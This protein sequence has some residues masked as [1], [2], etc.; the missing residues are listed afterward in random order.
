MFWRKCVLFILHLVDGHAAGGAVGWGT[1]LQAERSRVRFP[2]VSS[3]FFIDIILQATLWSWGWLSL[4]RNE[5]QEYFLGGK[6]GRCVKSDNLITFMCRLSW[7]LRSSSSWN[8]QGLITPWPG[9]SVGIA[10]DH[11][12]DGPGSNPDGDEIFRPTR[13]ALGP[14]QPPVQWV[15]GLSPEVEAAGTWGWHPHTI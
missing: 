2:M 13:P 5:Y 3:E 7:Y 12:L 10:I 8:P 6:G 4:Y 9:S 15:P 1:V 14:T 11:G